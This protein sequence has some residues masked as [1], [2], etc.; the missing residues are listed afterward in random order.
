MATMNMDKRKW[1]VLCNTGDIGAALRVLLVWLFVALFICFCFL[2]RLR[3]LHGASCPL[4]L[5]VYR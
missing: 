1:L 2:W 5:L 4:S 3:S